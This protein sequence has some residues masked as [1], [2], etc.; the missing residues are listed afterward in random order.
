MLPQLKPEPVEVRCQQRRSVSVPVLPKA[1]EWVEW[2]PELSGPGKARLS[3]KASTWVV[4]VLASVR[5]SEGLRRVE[6]E[7]L[8]AYE[9]K[10]LIRQ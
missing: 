7:C 4:D 2:V 3:K 9:E 5:T 8:D 1:D 6:H 10:G